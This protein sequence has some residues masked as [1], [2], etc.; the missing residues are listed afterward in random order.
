[1]AFEG[2]KTQFPNFFVLYNRVLFIK[3]ILVSFIYHLLYIFFCIKI[4]SL[5]I[6]TTYEE[7]MNKAIL[8]ELVE[9]LINNTEEILA[10]KGVKADNSISLN[11]NKSHLKAVLG[12]SVNDTSKGSLVFNY[13]NNR[14]SL[15]TQGINEE[16]VNK[17]EPKLIEEL[18]K[19]HT[20]HH[21][22]TY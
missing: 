2:T 1:M 8:L 6:F 19:I 10:L 14:L 5:F 20:E 3:K 9:S 7:L 18:Q 12:V 22:K 16:I 15:T 13:K 17:I 21:D 4:S 11:S